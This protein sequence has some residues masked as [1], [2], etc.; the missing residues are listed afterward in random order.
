[1]LATG[2]L[3][4]LWCSSVLLIIIKDPLTVGIKF[5]AFLS[6]TLLFEII[7]RL[8]STIDVVHRRSTCLASRL[9]IGIASLRRS[10]SGGL[11]RLTHVT[12][13]IA[14]FQQ[15]Y[16]RQDMKSYITAQI[17]IKFATVRTEHVHEKYR[18]QSDP[19]LLKPQ[20]RCHADRRLGVGVLHVVNLHSINRPY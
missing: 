10:E 6:S 12:C 11:N 5:Q 3:L 17:V 13:E 20:G 16:P 4:E 19:P 9:Y 8:M 15:D 18:W 14:H 2:L 1:M 7:W